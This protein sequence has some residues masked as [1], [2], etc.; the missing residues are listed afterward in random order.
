VLVG[1]YLF[2]AVK[3]EAVKRAADEYSLRLLNAV[4]AIPPAKKARNK[5]QKPKQGF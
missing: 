3:P 5:R 2:F 1:I 4:E